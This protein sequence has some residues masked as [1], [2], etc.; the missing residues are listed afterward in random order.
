MVVA[1]GVA[2]YVGLAVVI[3][4]FLSLSSRWER[5]IGGLI[6]ADLTRLAAAGAGDGPFTGAGRRVSAM[7]GGNEPV[8]A[9]CEEQVVGAGV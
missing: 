5:A 2:A 4:R 8:A 7:R 9:T 6:E 3:G 1:I